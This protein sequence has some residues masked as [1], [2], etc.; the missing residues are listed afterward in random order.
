MLIDRVE[1]RAYLRIGA[2][3]KRLRELGMS[4]KAIAQALG[5]SDKTVV[6]AISRL[7]VLGASISNQNNI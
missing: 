5:A 4:D 3:A 6:K 1:M 2:R 7:N